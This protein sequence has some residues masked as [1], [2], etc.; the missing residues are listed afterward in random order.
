MERGMMKLFGTKKLVSTRNSF[1]GENQNQKKNQS[2]GTL[3]PINPKNLILLT[4]F[5]NFIDPQHF[6]YDTDYI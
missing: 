3:N 5:Y 1:A 2:K 6:I 4:N